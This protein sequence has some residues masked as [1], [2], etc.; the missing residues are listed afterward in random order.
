ML[1][2]DLEGEDFIIE[3]RINDEPILE[4]RPMT[5]EEVRERLL[6]DRQPVDLFRLEM[7]RWAIHTC[8][9]G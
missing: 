6:A 2:E 7:E 8:L 9:N 4:A 1:Q 5:R 3:G